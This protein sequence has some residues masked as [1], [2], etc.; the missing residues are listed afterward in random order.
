MQGIKPTPD[1]LSHLTRFK[2]FGPK[3]I[4]VNVS[5]I[6]GREATMRGLRSRQQDRL[7][8][9]GLPFASHDVHIHLRVIYLASIFRSRTV[10]CDRVHIPANRVP[11][12]F[13]THN[14]CSWSHPRLPFTN[15]VVRV[16][17]P[18]PYTSKR[19]SG[20]F[21]Y[22][23]ATCSLCRLSHPRVLVAISA[24]KAITDRHPA[25]GCDRKQ[26]PVLGNFSFSRQTW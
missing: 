13:A 4:E 25:V 20:V 26:Q 3:D 16:S 19:V 7:Y 18:R 15:C 6:L 2:T 1:K 24:S 10:W 17:R 12:V 21:A 8:F 14:L 9:G 23:Q 22:S 11:G 5:A